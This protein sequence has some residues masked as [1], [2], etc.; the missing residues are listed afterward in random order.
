MKPTPSEKNQVLG[1]LDAL[2]DDLI[3]LRD[4]DLDTLGYE[5]LRAR[6]RDT[7]LTAKEIEAIFAQ[8]PQP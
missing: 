2:Q 3:R 1:L 5:S 7:L 4:Q 6:W 8:L